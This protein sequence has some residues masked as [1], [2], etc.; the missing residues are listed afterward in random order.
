MVGIH[1]QVAYLYLLL[2]CGFGLLG[3]K[4]LLLVVAV[5]VLVAELAS[6]GGNVSN[7]LL[8]TPAEHGSQVEHGAFGILLDGH[9]LECADLLQLGI[10]RPATNR[11][12]IT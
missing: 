12:L 11:G 2:S 6:E 4:N 1:A 7:D 9:L 5:N 8:A 3:P 10:L